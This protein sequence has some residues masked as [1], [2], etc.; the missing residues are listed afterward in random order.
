[1]GK[2]YKQEFIQKVKKKSEDDLQANSTTANN[3]GK[4]SQDDK[5]RKE[6][7]ADTMDLRK[8]PA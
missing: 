6:R 7:N 2:N 3:N 4:Q 1:M 5:G 8:R